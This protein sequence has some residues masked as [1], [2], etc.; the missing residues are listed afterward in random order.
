MTRAERQNE[1]EGEREGE[2]THSIDSVVRPCR[3]LHRYELELDVRVMGY[4]G[5]NAAHAVFH[6]MFLDLVKCS[7][8]SKV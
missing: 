7:R 5:G 3:P 8:S 6:W 1:K 4:C 2:D